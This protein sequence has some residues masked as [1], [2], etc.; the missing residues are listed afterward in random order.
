MGNATWD[1]ATKPE[2]TLNMFDLKISEPKSSNPFLDGTYEKKAPRR[3]S[4]TLRSD[5]LPLQ[6]DF[7]CSFKD[8]DDAALSRS[9][10]KRSLAEVSDMEVFVVP[11][12][13]NKVPKKLDTRTLSTDDLEALHKE[14][15]FMYYSIPEVRRAVME[16]RDV[17][18]KD[19][20]T[21]RP[22]KR[23][24]AISYESADI[25]DGL[26]FAVDDLDIPS[27]GEGYFHA[28]V[29]SENEDMFMSIFD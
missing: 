12:F 10:S 14:D 1:T 29:D 23:C 22:V 25:M 16:G 20:D 27:L 13:Q 24:S 26:D 5:L 19:I 28:S 11:T 7:R 21:S 17:D 15:A 9:S 8:K 2:S 3:S 18:F 4:R 6:E